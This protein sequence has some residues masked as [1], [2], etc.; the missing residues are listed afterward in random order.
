[1]SLEDKAALVTGGGSGVGL[2]V[3]VALAGE[4]CRVVICGRDEAKL[5]AAAAS[6]SGSPPIVPCPCDVADRRRVR[7]MIDWF[8]AELGPVEILVNSA[9]INVPKRTMSALEPE[10]WDR[11]LAVNLTGTYNVVHAALPGMRRKRGGLIVNICSIAGKRAIPLGGIAYNAAKFGVTALSTTLAL[12]E[13]Q[14]GI[15]VTNLCPGEVRTPI[16]RQR[17]TPPPPE[18]LAE[19]LDPETIADCVLHIAKLPPQAVV[20][21]LV[22]TP[23]YQDYA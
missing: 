5:Q 16:L 14:Y 9:G 21:E 22:I 23:L 19:M 4:G 2:A 18:R 1:M 20:R 8:E 11:M 7:T 3:A 10:D 12:E 13:R 17:L 6:H 15:R